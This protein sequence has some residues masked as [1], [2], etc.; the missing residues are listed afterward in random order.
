MVINMRNAIC[1]EG[2][3]LTWVALLF[4]L[5]TVARLANTMLSFSFQKLFSQLILNILAF[6][7]SMHSAWILQ[8]STL[9]AAWNYYILCGRFLGIV[10]FGE[11]TL[12]HKT[13]WIKLLFFLVHW[14]GHYNCVFI[15]FHIS[16]TLRAPYKNKSTFTLQSGEVNHIQ[17]RVDQNSD[18]G[19]KLISVQPA[20]SCDSDETETG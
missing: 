8:Y 10:R 14:Y 19:C 3:V 13:L 9:P 7:R 18:D 2:I 5:Y 12:M 1:V 16:R 17:T 15:L 20:G 6:I 4:I 11:I